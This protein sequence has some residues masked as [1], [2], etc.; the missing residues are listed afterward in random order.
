[1]RQFL[2]AL[3]I[4]ALCST[5]SKAQTWLDITPASG[6]APGA[7]AYSSAILDI[8]SNQI[9]VFAGA[10]GTGFIG[11]VWGFD[12]GTNM[13]TDLTPPTGPA[14]TNRRT[15]ASIY[16]PAGARMVMWSGQATGVFFNDVWQFDL[17]SNTWTEFTP[18]GGP[19]NIRYGV[20]A[21]F[22]PVAGDLVTF[23]GFTSLGRFDD[24]WRFNPV[25]DTWSDA[26]M[27]SPPLK[28]CLHSASYDSREHRMIMYGGQNAGWRDDIWALDLTTDTWTDLTPAIRPPGRFFTAHVYDAANH[29]STVFGGST[30]S[31][32]VNEAWV[33]DLWTEEWTQLAPTGTPPSVR[34][35]SAGVYDAANDRMIVFGGFDG[36]YYNE[37]W[38]LQNLSGTVTSARTQTP[39]GITLGQNFPNP[40]NPSTRITFSIDSTSPMTITVHSVTGRHI[41]TLIKGVVPAGSHQAVWDGRD[42]NSRPVA[43]GVYFYRLKTEAQQLTRTMVLLK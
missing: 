42:E 37:V 10:D 3:T 24:V 5:A 11:G 32:L 16:D 7:R 41:R 38:S 6:P 29:R 23:A 18:S 17:T 36:G 26:S 2:W 12:L 39:A 13:W 14:P 25:S 28:R 1:M 35:G 27:P 30:P 31:G 4:V 9:V 19:P 34:E 43:S 8:A 40:F 15:P 22:D 20:A 21:T 33:F